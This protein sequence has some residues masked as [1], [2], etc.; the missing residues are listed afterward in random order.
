ERAIQVT[1]GEQAADRLTPQRRDPTQPGVFP[2]RVN[3]RLREHATIAD[4]DDP[5]EA[6]LARELGDL[7]GDSG[8]VTRVAGIDLDGDGSSRGITQD[9]VDEDRPAGLAIAVMTP[10]RQG[11]LLSLV[12]AAADV[13]EDQSPL[14]EVALGELGLHRLLAAE[15]PVHGG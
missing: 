2:Q 1:I 4:Q 9:A 7:I 12:I 10:A 11:T 8:G 6:E 3:L 15:Q 13:V 5:G 14:G